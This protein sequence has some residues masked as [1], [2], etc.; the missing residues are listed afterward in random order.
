MSLPRVRDN[1]FSLADLV[2]ALVILTTVIFGA[3][4]LYA[5]MT[6][7]K[8]DL[9]SS[10]EAETV[11]LSLHE[12]ERGRLFS[13]PLGTSEIEPVEVGGRRYEVSMTLEPLD[14]FSDGELRKAE[15]TARYEIRGVKK[16]R[17]VIRRIERID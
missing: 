10:R 16:E 13:Y 4:R 11:L 15:Y 1:G 6:R 7:K 2:F 14:G 17:K 9:I 5:D 3:M 12:K 8:L